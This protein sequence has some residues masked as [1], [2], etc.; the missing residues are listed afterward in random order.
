ML[1][2]ENQAT[3]PQIDRITVSLHAASR[4]VADWRKKGVSHLTNV[5]RYAREHGAAGVLRADE[6]YALFFMDEGKLRQ[7]TWARARIRST[8]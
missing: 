1:T 7:R 2:G 6:S 4:T 8:N 5:K 3:A